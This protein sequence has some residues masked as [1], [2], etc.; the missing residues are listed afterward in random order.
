MTLAE[1]DSW[2]EPTTRSITDTA[3]HGTARVSG[4]D[5]MHPRLEHR[6]GWATHPGPLPIVEGTLIRLAVDH[7]PGQREA[8]PVWLWSSQTS[9]DSTTALLTSPSR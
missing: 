8:K 4:W 2:P 1:P 6:G 5:R 3:R 9:A 7:L